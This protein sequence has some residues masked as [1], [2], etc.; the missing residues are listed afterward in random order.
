MKFSYSND[1]MGLAEDI[2]TLGQA[3]AQAFGIISGWVGD[4][5]VDRMI[6]HDMVPD[7]SRV[8]QIACLSC[9]T[10]LRRALSDVEL[11]T[12]KFTTESW[13]QMV[14]DGFRSEAPCRHFEQFEAFVEGVE[15]GGKYSL[16]IMADIEVHARLIEVGKA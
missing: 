14:H 1:P 9:G 2:D 11:D 8:Y 5:E 7:G 16:K 4:Q 3:V 12:K 6:S 13:V 10:A 15:T